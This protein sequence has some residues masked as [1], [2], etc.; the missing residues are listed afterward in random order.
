MVQF[1]LDWGANIK[2]HGVK[3]L[4][5]LSSLAANC[6]SL[7]QVKLPRYMIVEQDQRHARGNSRLPKVLPFGW[8]VD[9][10]CIKGAVVFPDCGLAT[11][12][13]SAS[14]VLGPSL[15]VEMPTTAYDPPFSASA[16]KLSL[17]TSSSLLPSSRRHPQKSSVDSSE[18]T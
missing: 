10:R 2:H 14:T 9:E 8:A 1:L 4:L 16:Q 15:W 17:V 5:P 11:L 13:E 18:I 12:L 7:E 3:A 6:G